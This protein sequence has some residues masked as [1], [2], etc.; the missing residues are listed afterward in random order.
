MQALPDE[1][2]YSPMTARRVAERRLEVEEWGSSSPAERAAAA[3]EAG[4][5][6]RIRHE[7]FQRAVVRGRLVVAD[8]LARFLRRRG[9]VRVFLARPVAVVAAGRRVVMA[10]IAIECAGMSGGRRGRTQPKRGQ[11]PNR[12]L[13]DLHRCLM[14]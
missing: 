9:H 2:G 1:G 3:G 12:D 13:Y 5:Q 6:A 10:A 4:L 11:S 8:V 14:A 7:I